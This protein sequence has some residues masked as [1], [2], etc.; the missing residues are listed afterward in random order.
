M[1]TFGS[2]TE[3]YSQNV[4]GKWINELGSMLVID[5]IRADHTIQGRYL[6]SSGVDGKIFPLFG[7]INKI[8]SGNI[9]I[10][11]TVHWGEYGSITSWT[12]YLSSNDADPY[13]KTMWHLVR[14]QEENEWERIITNSST[15]R[16][17]VP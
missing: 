5:S 11:F 16:P 8:E 6:S 12:G 10:S 15:F 1:M 7:F 2:L 9:G 3:A 14:P 13:I 4:S 17:K